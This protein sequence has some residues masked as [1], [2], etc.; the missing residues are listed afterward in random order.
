M[1]RLEPIPSPP[2]ALW[3][4]V[5]HRVLPFAVFAGVL[6]LVATI[7]Q[8]DLRGTHLF[9]EVEAV[10][11][12][13]TTIEAGLLAELRVGRFDAVR[14]G[15][16]LGTVEVS[17]A[18]TARRELETAAAELRIMRARM[19]VDEARNI[20]DLE[21]LRTRW[22][23]ARVALAGARVGLERARLD[24]ERNTRLHAG[25]IISDAEF[26]LSRAI[27]EA[28]RAEVAERETLVSGLAE[29]LPRLDAAIAADQAEALLTL[30]EA[31]AAQESLLSQTRTLRLRAPQDGYISAVNHLPGERL[32]AGAVVAR[33]T[34]PRSHRVIGYVR[35]PLNVTP[36][37][38][39]AVE[40]R[41]RS[42]PP[43]VIPS[44]VIKVGNH[45][46]MVSSPLRLRGFDNATARGL[47]FL[48]ELPPE[49]ALHPG[50]LVD[51]VLRP[52]ASRN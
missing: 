42:R 17:S 9:G 6:A 47:P 1:E 38:G 50:E 41:T 15:E 16:I 43:L 23:E 7:W 44:T 25:Q 37:V 34:A 32:P 3:R 11:A 18:E 19:A 48:V 30:E 40:V 31:V 4:E 28:L 13:V 12:D 39:M 5:R 10:H 35:Q 26:E 45:L 21:A 52:A 20:Q 2:G 27:F 24:H 29:T 14:A 22:L 8:R 51:L 33:V 46:E 49:A 36:Q